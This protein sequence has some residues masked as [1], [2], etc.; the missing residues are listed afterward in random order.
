MNFWVR[1]VAVFAVLG[2]V[3]LAFTFEWPS[4]STVQRGYR[5]LGM[6]QIYNQVAVAAAIQNNVPPA[7]IDPV[8]PAGVKSS[9][10]YQNVQ[11]LG[12]VDANEFIRI[13]T[14]ITEW[15]SPVQG[16]AYCHAEGEELS[17]DTLYTKRVARRMIQMTR[18]INTDWK[19]HVADT[20]VNCYTCHRG[21]PVP[22]QI[23]F[24]EPERGPLGLAG[25]PAGQNIAAKS[26]GL[27]SLPSDPFTPFLYQT[28]PI[29]VASATA[30][31]DGNLTSIKQT[32]WT[33]SLMMHMSSGL[34]VNCTFCHNSRNFSGWSESSPQRVTSWHGLR[35]VADLNINY[36]G[37]L[38]GEYPPARLGPLGDAAK[39]NCATCHQGAYKPL[40]GAAMLSDYPALGAP[41]AQ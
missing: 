25:N 27:S 26:A 9:E 8:D 32:E 19:A 18:A 28:A 23:W 13:M 22:A 11:V 16:C 1:F 17:A 35:M 4:T 40:L 37:P 14:A 41:A 39:A 5:G 34:G 24:K 7:V 31:P 21:Q 36:L 38:Q 15:V 20:G 2:A 12:D 3:G 10:A 29:R 33:Y 30:L 6:E